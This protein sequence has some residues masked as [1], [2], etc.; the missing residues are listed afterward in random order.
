[1]VSADLYAMLSN[2]KDIFSAV[3]NL[4]VPSIVPF[5]NLQMKQKYKEL[6]LV[7]AK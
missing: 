2:S 5:E 7:I 3:M 1:M 6:S 4:Q